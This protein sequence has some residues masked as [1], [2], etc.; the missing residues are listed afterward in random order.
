MRKLLAKSQVKK[1]HAK[2]ER[3][4]DPYSFRCIPQVHGA[5]KDALA[6]LGD[7]LVLE[8]NSATDNPL[9]FPGKGDSIS[10]GNFHG[11][12]I[13]MPLDY[14]ANAICAWGNISERR[15]ST[16]MHPSMSGLPA[17]LTPQPGLN[18]GLMITQVVSAALVSENKNHANPASSDTV[19]TSADQEDHVSMANFAARKLRTAVINAQRVIAIELH[20]AAQ[21]REFNKTLQA[22]V[23][24]QAA[25]E[26]IRKNVPP[27]KSDRYMTP[28]LDRITTLVADGSIRVAVERKVGKLRE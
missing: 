22:G 5:A 21:G 1:S 19:T 6:H 3:V 23:G 10:A 9:V 13:A 26:F 17:F 18:S 12:P 28:E 2:C 14:A 20:A 4:Q 24:A 25:Y 27:L 11:H 7:A 8:A 15:M 16:L